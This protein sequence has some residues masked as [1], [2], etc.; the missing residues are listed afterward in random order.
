MMYRITALSFPHKQLIKPKVLR[1]GLPQ[2]PRVKKMLL[3]SYIPETCHEEGTESLI[4]IIQGSKFEN[5]TDL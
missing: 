5:I 2:N 3:F 4:L 1:Q